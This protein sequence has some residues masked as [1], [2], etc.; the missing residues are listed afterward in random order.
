MLDLLLE[1][2][3]VLHVLAYQTANDQYVAQ[4][5]E[6]FYLIV[7]Q[8]NLQLDLAILSTGSEDDTPPTPLPSLVRPH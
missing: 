7:D 2:R 8:I 4:T 5:W 6:R 1:L 3:Q